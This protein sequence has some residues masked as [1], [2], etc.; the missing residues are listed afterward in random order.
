MAEGE[1]QVQPTEIANEA[2]IDVS[3]AQI[4]SEPASLVE[5]SS[6]EVEAEATPKDVLVL[7]DTGHVIWNEVVIAKLIP[8]QPFLEPKLALLGE[9]LNQEETF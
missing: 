8:N 3:E 2:E 9:E 6:N 1:E 5:T 4:V 7:D